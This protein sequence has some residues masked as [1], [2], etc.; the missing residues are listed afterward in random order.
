MWQLEGNCCVLKE[1]LSY[2]WQ[3]MDFISQ[4]I[5]I[6]AWIRM[7]WS[8]ASILKNIHISSNYHRKIFRESV[9]VCVS[10]Y[11]KILFL[12]GKCFSE[13]TLFIATGF[14]IFFLFFVCLW[15]KK[16]SMFIYFYLNIFFSHWGET[17]SQEICEDYFI[18]FLFCQV[19]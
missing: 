15:H 2:V 8:K 17:G 7:A 4:W 12:F 13:H 3:H 10:E 11:I 6:Y 9:C 18:F 19:N 14:I 16:I 1:S 5:V